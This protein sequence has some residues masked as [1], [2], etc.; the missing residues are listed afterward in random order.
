MDDQIVPFG[1]GDDNNVFHIRG[2]TFT[3]AESKRDSNA[4][5][6]ELYNLLPTERG[7]SPVDIITAVYHDLIVQ[8]DHEV[9]ANPTPEFW[10]KFRLDFK[11]R[12]IPLNEWGL[13]GL[14][15]AFGLSEECISMLADTVGFSGPFF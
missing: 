15:R 11:Y 1:M 14:Y 5:W 4:I 7:K 8:N 9:P 10:Q 6:S 3:V 13:W 2:R 12:T